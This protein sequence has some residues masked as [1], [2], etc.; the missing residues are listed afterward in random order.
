[1]QVLLAFAGG[2]S[3]SAAARELTPSRQTITAHFQSFRRIWSLSLQHEPIFF[4]GEG[5]YEVDEFFLTHVK[6]ESGEV[7]DMWVQ[8]FY[9]RRTQCYKAIIVPNRSSQTLI[10][11]VRDNLPPHSVIFSDEWPGYH[12][13]SRRGYAHYTVNHSRNE[14]S[15]EA[16]IRGQTL[17][18]STNSLEG[19]HRH[20]RSMLANKSRRR[21]NN[22]RLLLDEFTYR[23]S[24]RSLFG[25][26]KI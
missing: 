24:G 5:P 6:T 3:A 4:T 15:R 2:Q 18:V 8:D 11:N 12:G 14:Y 25:P 20:V 22:I 26:F 16:R 23:H 9:D 13:L 21:V 19:L 17:L 10:G 7:R 1:M